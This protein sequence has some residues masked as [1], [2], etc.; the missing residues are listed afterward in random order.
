MKSLSLT[1]TKEGPR[2]N[3]EVLYWGGEEENIF[4]LTRCFWDQ[5]TTSSVKCDYW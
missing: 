2:S 4:L 5:K 1:V 3:D